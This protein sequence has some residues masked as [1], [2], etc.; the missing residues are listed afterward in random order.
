MT[1]FLTNEERQFSMVII[2]WTRG[3]CRK[4]WGR[5]KGGRMSVHGACS[6]QPLW[7]LWMLRSIL[8]RVSGTT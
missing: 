2:V 3:K 1:L 6:G 4:G 8:V 5:F 7:C